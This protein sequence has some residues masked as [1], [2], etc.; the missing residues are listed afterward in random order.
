MVTS[1]PAIYPIFAPATGRRKF[2]HPSWL[3]STESH[4]T[5][6]SWGQTTFYAYLSNIWQ[7]TNILTSRWLPCFVRY[8]TF[9][10]PTLVYGCMAIPP[11]YIQSRCIVCC[12]KI[13]DFLSKCRKTLYHM[14]ASNFTWKCVVVRYKMWHRHVAKPKCDWKPMVCWP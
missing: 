7:K 9:T 8:Q 14:A 2:H 5:S 10:T 13:F 11:N 12:N 1:T 6:T 3:P 4:G